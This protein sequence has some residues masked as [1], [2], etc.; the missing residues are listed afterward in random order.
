MKCLRMDQRNLESMPGCCGNYGHPSDVVL[1][2]G[3]TCESCK[4]KEILSGE[5]EMSGKLVI[6]FDS[7]LFLRKPLSGLVGPLA[8]P[9]NIGRMLWYV[10]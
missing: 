4:W 6:F 7:L 5:F 9:Q 8:S 3:Y 10:C 1:L 2:A